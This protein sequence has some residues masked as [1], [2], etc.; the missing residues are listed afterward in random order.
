M[1]TTPY[2]GHYV[3]EEVMRRDFELMRHNNI[4]AVRLSH[5]PQGHRFYELASEYGLYVYDE[6]NI[7]SHGMGYDLRK[8]G[9]LGN[10]PDWLDAHLYR[11]RNLYEHDKNYPCVC[12][13]SLGNE[14][15]NG[16][17]FYE[18]YQWLKAADAPWMSRP[19]SY[20]RALWN[21]TRTCLS[22]NIRRRNGSP[23]WGKVGWT[24][25]SSPLNTPMRWATARE[26]CGDNGNLSTN[27]TTCRVDSSGT[28]LT[29]ESWPSTPKIAHD[30]AT[31]SR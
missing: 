19:V 12:F 23:K 25:P 11:T 1:S 22:H 4:N 3:T 14:A 30:G 9:T 16:V 7:E 18:T 17:N 20:E 6:A 31:P 29:K 28:G 5:Y 24:V 21:G 13:W 8:G 2:T 26:T 10:N 15:G 27:T